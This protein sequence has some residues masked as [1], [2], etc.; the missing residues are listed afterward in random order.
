MLDVRTFLVVLSSSDL[1]TAVLIFSYWISHRRDHAL[2]YFFLSKCI[3][4]LTWFFIFLERMNISITV[5]IAANMLLYFAIYL[6]ITSLLRL[7]HCYRRFT[8]DI[9]L[10]LLAG[11][12]LGSFI[13]Y[14]K[15]NQI[16]ALFIYFAAGLGI[17]I[18][19]PAVYMHLK[20]KESPLI[21]VMSFLF[22]CNIALSVAIPF[23]NILRMLSL[24][25]ISEDWMQIIALFGIYLVFFLSNIGFIMINNEIIA[26]KLT[27]Q[28]TIDDLTQA[29]NR[30]AFFEQTG[31]WIEKHRRN[32]APLSFLLF[33][34]DNFKSVNDTYGHEVGDLVLRDLSSRIYVLLR[35]SMIF[36]R[37]G[38]DEF[39]LL[40]PGADEANSAQ[41]AEK[42]RAAIADAS[43]RLPEGRLSY[44]IS[45]GLLT[46][47]P[48]SRTTVES[49]YVSCDAALYAAK[50]NGKNTVYRGQHEAAAAGSVDWQQETGR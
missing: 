20:R 22:F 26:L 30:R 21:R 41:F 18:V 11:G 43:V 38:G 12:I 42:M 32:H 49:L 29:L 45:V 15:Y 47:H 25:P 1:L 9:Y 2:R 16:D 40:M 17:F 3:F 13:F 5:L 7:I 19:I 8:R 10:L 28:A 35:G 37:F 23:V 34:I 44:S 6:E 31:K 14:G 48:D 36:G 39:C 27:R 50:K 4:A 33:D 24:L 46:L